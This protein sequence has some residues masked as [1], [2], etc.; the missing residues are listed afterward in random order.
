MPDTNQT[1]SLVDPEEMSRL[2]T[3][4][5]ERS[6][7]IIQAFCERQAADGGFQIP[8]PMVIG[9]AFMELGT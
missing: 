8:D 7:S 5:A 1:N 9:R 6:Q 2:M 3:D 4:F